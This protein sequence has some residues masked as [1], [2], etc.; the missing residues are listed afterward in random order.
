[1]TIELISFAGSTYTLSL[2]AVFKE[3]GL[4]YKVSPPAKYTDIKT[5]EFLATKNPL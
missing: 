3:L 4:S 2:V 5:P 1:M